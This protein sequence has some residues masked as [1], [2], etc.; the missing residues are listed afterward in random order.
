LGS[1]CLVDRRPRTLSERGR[2]LFARLGDVVSGEMAAWVRMQAAIGAETR[3][4]READEETRRLADLYHRK[5]AGVA[6]MQSAFLP[7][8]LPNILNLSFSAHYQTADAEDRVGGDWYDAF[9]LDEKRV[10]ITVGDVAG[11]GL[12]AAG[13]MA[14]LLISLRALSMQD[15]EPDELLFMLDGIIRREH[16]DMIASA[17]VGVLDSVTGDLT[18]ANAGHPEPLLCTPGASTYALEQYGYLLGVPTLEFAPTL[19]RT[20]MHRNSLLLLYTDGLTEATRDILE[21]ETRLRAALD[22]AAGRVSWDTAREIADDVLRGR[23]SHDDLAVLT[24]RF[25]GRQG[26]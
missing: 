22:S 3:A 11:H 24:V 26:A 7:R 20:T 19:H 10:L 17:F 1:L 14:K 13:V 21:G 23:I 2:R 12:V 4:R 18:Y 5:N 6:A 16:P 25:N 15:V 8:A 9:A